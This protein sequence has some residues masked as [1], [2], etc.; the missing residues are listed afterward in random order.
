MNWKPTA[1]LETLKYRAKLFAGI[2]QFFDA[3]DVTEVDVPVLAKTGV[4]DLHIDA[5]EAKI[6]TETWYLQSSPEYYMKRLLAAGAS[7][8]Y[9]LGKAFRKGEVGRKH[10]Q[11]FTLLEWYRLGWDEFQLMNEIAELLQALGVNTASYQIMT[12]ADV[13]EQQVGANPHQATL[14][15]L[16]SLASDIAGTDFS[17]EVR[18]ICLDLIFSLAVEPQLPTGLVFVHDYP[19]CQSALA[20][21]DNDRQNNKVARRFEA[22]LNGIELANGYFELRDTVELQ[23]RFELDL[24]QRHEIGKPIV[25]IDQ[26]LL[27]AMYSGLPVCSGVALGVDR[28]LMQLLNFNDISHVIPFADDGVVR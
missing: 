2:R 26:H 9:Y 15:V 19:S 12:Y 22:F 24:M 25:P 21:L 5:I 14:N 8:I 4:T 7:S 13:F 27:A 6:G 18:S 28:L 11:E 23:S 17:R 20:Q 1:E 10:R 16:Q 3:Q